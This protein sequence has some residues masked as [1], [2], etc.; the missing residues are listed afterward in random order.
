MTEEIAG[1]VSRELSGEPVAVV[2]DG[3]IWLSGMNANV[4]VYAQRIK[5]ALDACG[6]DVTE[7]ED[8]DGG[9]YLS[10]PAAKPTEVGR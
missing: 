1:I 7:P 5:A 3:G 6:Y 10:V 9:L 8:Q 4:G 2:E